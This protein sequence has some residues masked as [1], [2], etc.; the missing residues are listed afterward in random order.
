MKGI[1]CASRLA[2]PLAAGLRHFAPR[3]EFFA[4]Y[5]PPKKTDWILFAALRRRELCE[6]FYKLNQPSH[7]AKAGL[8]SG[9]V[10]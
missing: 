2:L 6:T 4:A 8:I 5:T 9:K 7:P 1:R 10:V 3:K